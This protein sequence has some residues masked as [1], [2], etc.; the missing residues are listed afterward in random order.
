MQ[1]WGYLRKG[2]SAPQESFI[3]TEDAHP[4]PSQQNPRPV[5]SLIGGHLDHTVFRLM[6]A[7]NTHKGQ[8]A[9]ARGSPGSMPFCLRG[10]HSAVAPRRRKLMGQFATSTLEDAPRRQATGRGHSLVPCGHL[11]DPRCLL[12]PLSG[13]SQSPAT[14][15]LVAPSSGRFPIPPVLPSPSPPPPAPGPREPAP[16]SWGSAEERAAGGGAVVP[17]GQLHTVAEDH[18]M[19]GG[20]G[21]AWGLAA[22]AAPGHGLPRTVPVARA[23]PSYRSS[24]APPSSVQ[25]RP[26][27]S[28]PPGSLKSPGICSSSPPAAPPAAQLL[29]ALGFLCIPRWDAPYQPLPAFGCGTDYFFSS[30]FAPQSLPTSPAGM[31]WRGWGAS[32]G[33]PRLV[34]PSVR[35]VSPRFAGILADPGHSG[36]PA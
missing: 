31:G 25:P 19:S 8:H 1:N 21:P 23:W 13:S 33:M 32:G 26:R 18:P 27:Q 7:P 34:H 15:G 12:M 6:R 22:A 28:L 24:P 16:T 9:S 17:G 20:D 4:I 3:P 36:R 10:G 29:P 5:L 2:K 30:T 35:G 11:R 14:L